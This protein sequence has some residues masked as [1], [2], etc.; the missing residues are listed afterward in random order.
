VIPVPFLYMIAELSLADAGM[1]FVSASGC[2]GTYLEELPQIFPTW[3]FQPS[4]IQSANAS[5]LRSHASAL[6]LLGT[7]LASRL[8]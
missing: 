6:C 3:I 5:V 7:K 1:Q 2:F 4:G 8:G